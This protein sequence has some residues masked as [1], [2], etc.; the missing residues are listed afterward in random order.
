MLK[1]FWLHPVRHRREDRSWARSTAPAGARA[2]LHRRGSRRRAPAAGGG[3]PAQLPRAT[4]SS[5][6]V[7]RRDERH[8]DRA[9]GNLRPG[10]LGRAYE[11][12]DGDPH[13]QRFVYGLSGAVWSAT[14]R[15][16]CACAAHPQRQINVNGGNFY[17]RTQP[18]GPTSRAG[19][20]ARWTEGS[21]NTSRQD[22]RDPG[23]SP[24]VG[25]RA[26]LKTQPSDSH[27][28]RALSEV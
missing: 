16:R 21:R 23:L 27:Y 4:M 2:R 14:R 1:T 12:R 8:D 3:R 10:A 7:R 28:A 13:R 18:S 5:H 9:G 24:V 15:A 25:I 6:G 19:W 20:D 17:A 22:H 11:A 26:V